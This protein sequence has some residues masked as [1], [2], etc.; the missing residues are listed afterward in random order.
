MNS[1]VIFQIQSALILLLIYFG[2]WKRRNRTLHV[3]TMITAIIWDVV[4]ILQIELT[5]GAINT[6]TKAMTNPALMNFHIAI[7]VTTVVLYGLLFFWGRKLL[8]GDQ[9]VRKFHRIAGYTAVLLRTTTLIT[10]YIIETQS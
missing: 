7:A 10:S 6:A 3:R 5:R 8:N 2:V 1:S 4:L 9:S